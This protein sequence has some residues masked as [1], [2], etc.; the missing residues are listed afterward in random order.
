M[1]AAAAV[2]VGTGMRPVVPPL[3]LL[4]SRVRH[5]PRY[6][7]SWRMMSCHAEWVE[8]YLDG[9]VY[10]QRKPNLFQVMVHPCGKQAMPP[11][12]DLV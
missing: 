5:A 4:A 8:H 1:L 6:G 3:A 7:H 12:R 11:L 9:K 10:S 2:V